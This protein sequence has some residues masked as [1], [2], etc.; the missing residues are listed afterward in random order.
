MGQDSEF[1]SQEL[2]NKILLACYASFFPLL[3]SDS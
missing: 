2:Q 1:R 3:N